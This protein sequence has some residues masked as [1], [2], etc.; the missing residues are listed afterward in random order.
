ME[1]AEAA[2]GPGAG[3]ASLPAAGAGRSTQIVRALLGGEGGLYGAA[4]LPM[5]GAEARDHA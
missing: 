4:R 3:N 1:G 2:G 5:L